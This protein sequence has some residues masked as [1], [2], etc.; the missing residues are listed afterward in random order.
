[1]K[2]TKVNT[3]VV[4]WA[5]RRAFEEGYR[6]AGGKE[7]F[8]AWVNSISRADLVVNGIIDKDVTFR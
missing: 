6:A 7:W 3:D 8:D 1:M 5:V 2:T 4:Q